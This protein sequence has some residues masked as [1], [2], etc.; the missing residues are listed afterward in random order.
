MTC[1][2]AIIRGSYT[3][4]P[5]IGKTFGPPRVLSSRRGLI[6]FSGPPKVSGLYHKTHHSGT[7]RR[8]TVKHRQAQTMV[9]ANA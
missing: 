2:R 1:D 7:L 9:A 4:A 3:V 5:G 8:D 6:Q